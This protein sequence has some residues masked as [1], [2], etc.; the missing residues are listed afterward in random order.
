LLDKQ[1]MLDEAFQPLAESFSMEYEFTF[2]HRKKRVAIFVSKE[3]HC[4]MELL[5]EWQNNELQ[6]ESPPVTGNHENAR[7]TADAVNIDY[8]YI[9]A[10]KHIRQDVQDKQIQLM[11]E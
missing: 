7:Q 4:V 3:T 6:M 1:A 2:K 10:H 5:W 9:P 8:H 11:T